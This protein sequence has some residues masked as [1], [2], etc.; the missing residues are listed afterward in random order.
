MKVW[1]SSIA[2]KFLD[3]IKGTNCYIP[4]M[5]ALTTE[6]RQGEIAALKWSDINLNYGFI[7]V[8]HNF[9]RVKNQY[10]LKEPKTERSKRSIAMMELTIK[11]LKKHK[12]RQMKLITNIEN[13][14]MGENFVCAWDDGSPFRPHYISDIFRD[15]VIKLKYPRIRFH[16]LRHTHATMLLS[17]EV[18]PKIVS[19]RLGHST[20]SITLDTYSHVLP[21]MQ[22]EA[23]KK[24]ND[25][26]ENKA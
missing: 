26:F 12:N 6:M 7:S 19:E 24:L 3:E 4:V 16:D 18:N 11:E 23:V 15:A 22:K 1:D 2:F 25:I 8:V 21:T 14:N 17:K 20:I 13:A 5:L 10:E 9:Q